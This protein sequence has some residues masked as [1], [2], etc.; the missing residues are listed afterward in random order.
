MAQQGFH[1]DFGNAVQTGEISE[2]LK[3]FEEAKRKSR[4]LRK[5]ISGLALLLALAAGFSFYLLVWRYAAI[6]E[7]KITQDT[8]DPAKVRFRFVVVS[9]GFLK[10]G[11]RN[12]SSGEP[13]RRGDRRDFEYKRDVPLSQEKFKVFIRSRS[14]ILPALYSESFSTR[15]L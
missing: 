3:Q 11:H 1:R 9:D 12:S 10:Y 7:V 2:L 13:V 14:G 6:D 8:A 5:A 15:G 4:K